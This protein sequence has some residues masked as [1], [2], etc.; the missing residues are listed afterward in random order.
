M[1]IKLNKSDCMDDWYTIVRAKHD[2]KEWME[3]CGH[4]SIRFMCSERLSPEA[5]I[6]GDGHEMLA[7]ADAIKRRGSAHFK[8]CAVSFTA[9]AAQFWSPKNSEKQVLISIEDADELADQIVAEL[10]PNAEL[11]GGL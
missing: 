8:R 5:C 3:K 2:G 10:T 9:G 6:E 7:I 11:K 1:K 4:N